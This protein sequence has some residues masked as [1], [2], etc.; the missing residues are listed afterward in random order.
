[1]A[2]KNKSE[3]EKSS[4]KFDRVVE[5]T[6][7]LT[8]AIYDAVLEKREQNRDETVL[9]FASEKH[10]QTRTLIEQQKSNDAL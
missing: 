2:K 6:G 5:L 8:T 3:S 9:R 4:P 7:Q 1:M 10:S